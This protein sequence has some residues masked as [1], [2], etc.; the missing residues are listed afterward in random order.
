VRTDDQIADRIRATIIEEIQAKRLLTQGEPENYL[1]RFIEVL[2]ER[3]TE[4]TL[5]ELHFRRY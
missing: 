3:L 1:P 2:T 5:D 4:L